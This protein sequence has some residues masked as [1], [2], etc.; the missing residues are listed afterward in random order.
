MLYQGN[1]L[2]NKKGAKLKHPFQI[3]YYISMINSL[4]GYMPNITPKAN[5]YKSLLYVSLNIGVRA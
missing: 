4:R 5:G 2:K 1:I 3:H